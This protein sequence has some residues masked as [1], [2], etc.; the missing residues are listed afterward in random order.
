MVLKLLKKV[1]GK[2]NGERGNCKTKNISYQK[3]HRKS[4]PLRT[5]G[6]KKKEGGPLK[7]CKA[8]WGDYREGGGKVPNIALWAWGGVDEEERG[9]RRVWWSRSE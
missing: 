4:S 2:R 1:I 6:G 3:G 5:R 7:D 9:R 8:T